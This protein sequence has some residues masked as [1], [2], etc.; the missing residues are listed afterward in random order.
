MTSPQGYRVLGLIN[1]IENEPECYSADCHGHSPKD[2]LL[3]LL[4][5]K[6]SLKSLDEETY[7]TRKKMVVFSVVMIL[8]TA[9]LFAGFIL[10]LVH[11]PIRKLARGTREWLI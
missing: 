2:K 3:G 7:R 10:R 1:P 8:L 9:L 4:D 5:V 11:I 6:I